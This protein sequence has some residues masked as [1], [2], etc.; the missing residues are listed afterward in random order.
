MV[1]AMQVPS[2]VATRSVGENDSPFPMLSTGA[3]VS[4]CLPEGPWEAVQCNPPVYSIAILTM[5]HPTT[6]PCCF[7]NHRTCFSLLCIDRIFAEPLV[8]VHGFTE[9]KI[10]APP[11][12]SDQKKLQRER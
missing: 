3:S 11:S 7:V 8:C 12:Q 2:A 10:S 4:S 9:Q 6:L 5:P 1:V